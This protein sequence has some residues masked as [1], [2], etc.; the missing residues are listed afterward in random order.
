MK[1]LKV[2]IDMQHKGGVTHHNYPPQYD[3]EK[4]Q[5]LGY[6]KGHCIGWVKDVDAPKF[7]ESPDI[8][9]M[10]RD[11]T[12]LDLED[13]NPQ[14]ERITDDKKVIQILAKVARGEILTQIE[15]DAINPDNPE[16]GINKTEPVAEG[17]DKLLSRT[18][19]G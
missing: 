11:N 13:W 12:V 14:V 10:N 15:K 2:K 8:V 16:R 19:L 6:G 4:I 3:A 7:L 18:D 17:I 5:I 9:E 1:I